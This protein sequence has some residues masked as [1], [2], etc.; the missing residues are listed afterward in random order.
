[1]QTQPKITNYLFIR[2]ITSFSRAEAAPKMAYKHKTSN[3]K[4]IFLPTR[5]I[6]FKLL[7]KTAKAGPRQIGQGRKFHSQGTTIEQAL[8]LVPTNLVSVNGGTNFLSH[9]KAEINSIYI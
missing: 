3:R 2:F 1:M 8:F 4:K 6:V 7:L 5:T 9:G